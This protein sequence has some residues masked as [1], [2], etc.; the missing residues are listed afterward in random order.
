MKWF[1]IRHNAEEVMKHYR[2]YPETQRL[3]IR[4]A[5]GRG[6]LLAESAVLHKSHLQWRRGAAGLAGRISSQV[7]L[8]GDSG[9]DGRI[10]FRRTRGFPYELAQEFGARAKPGKAMAIPLTAEAR[11]VEGPRRFPRKLF[12]LR[13]KDFGF[14]RTGLLVE[15]IASTRVV[16]QYAL[17]KSIPP[18][19][20]FRRTVLE[21]IPGIFAAIVRAVKRAQEGKK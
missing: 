10:G 20:R 13:K 17:V 14:D 8:A 12:L 16:A 3:A 6:L 21:Q 19:L 9:L 4:N 5:L 1:E 18:R 7:V 11:R 2:D 15:N